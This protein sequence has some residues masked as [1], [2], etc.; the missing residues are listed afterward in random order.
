[1]GPETTSSETEVL[2]FC[3]KNSCYN[4]I[5]EV[6]RLKLDGSNLCLINNWFYYCRM[7]FDSTDL[8]TRNSQKCGFFVTFCR[9]CRAC[10]LFRHRAPNAVFPLLQQTF[11]KISIQPQAN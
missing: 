3:F 6:W 8:R 2:F 11:P 10:F 4:L 1:M 5:A 7:W 9:G